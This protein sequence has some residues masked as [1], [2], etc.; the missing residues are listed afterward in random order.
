LA[1]KIYLGVGTKEG[2]TAKIQNDFVQN[3][4]KLN[5]IISKNKN[6][7][8][9]LLVQKG[10]IH[11]YSSWQDRLPYALEFLIGNN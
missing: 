3:V 6:V 9:H 4:R 1:S 2:D 7:Q 11:W 8:L 5:K 10:G